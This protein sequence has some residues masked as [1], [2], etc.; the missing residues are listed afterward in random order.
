M[1][2]LLA[3][4]S[5]RIYKIQK[6]D[7]GNIQVVKFNTVVMEAIS[8]QGIQANVNQASPVFWIINIAQKNLDRLNEVEMINEWENQNDPS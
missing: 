3:E 6:A 8:L 7:N 2:T 5:D 4:T 1:A